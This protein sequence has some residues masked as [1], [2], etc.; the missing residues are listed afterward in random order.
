MGLPSPQNGLWK[1]TATGKTRP[2]KQRRPCSV[3]RTSSVELR[4]LEP[5]T[6]C[7]PCRC[8]TSCATA[9]KSLGNP[10][11]EE[12]SSL[13][14]PVY[15]KLHFRFTRIGTSSGG[16]VPADRHFRVGATPARNRGRC[17]LLPV[18]QP[19]LRG[20]PPGRTPCCL[21]EWELRTPRFAARGAFGHHS[22]PWDPVSAAC[23]C[24]SAPGPQQP[25]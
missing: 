17:R 12:P 7:M 23:P 21:R 11:F 4:G 15:L 6:P 19:A 9:P 5:L 16:K 18:P 14:Q 24:Q 13:K 10:S 2:A 3:S 20:E 8:A 22:S 1:I 25:G